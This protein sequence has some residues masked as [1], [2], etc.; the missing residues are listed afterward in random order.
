M[1]TTFLSLRGAQATKQSQFDDNRTLYNFKRQCIE[2]SLYGVDIDPGA[3]EIAKLRLWLSLVVD[4]EEIKNIKPLP[5]LDYRIMQGNSLISEFMGI[6]FDDENSK[7]S[8]NDL[9]IKINELNN[10]LSDIESENASYYKRN[11]KFDQNLLGRKNELNKIISGLQKKKNQLLKKANT[12]QNNISSLIKEFEKKKNEFLNESNVTR[13]SQLKEEVDDLLVKIFETKLKKQKTDYFSVLKNIENK[14]SGLRNEKQKAE[15]IKTE[16]EKLYKESGFDLESA[17]KQLK[18]FSSERKIKPFFLWNLYFSEVFHNKGGFDVVIANPPYG[19]LNKRQN[20]AQTIVVTPQEFHYYK[21]S[22]EY[23]SARGGM[24][25][26]FRLFILKSIYLIQNSGVLSEIFPLAFIADASA[27]KLRKYILN[28]C[29][30]QLIEAFPERDNIRKR[31]FEEVKMSVCVMVLTGDKGN[32][33]D[34]FFIRIHYDRYVNALNE[35]TILNS[36]LIKLFDNNKYTIPLMFQ[37]DIDL[38]SKIY[39]KSIRIQDMGHCYTGEVDMTLGKKYISYNKNNAVLL[40]GAGIDR[41]LIQK[42]MSQGELLYLKA[43]KYLANASKEKIKHSQTQRIV[44]QAI[45][46]VNEKIRLKMTLIDENI[47]CANS[48]N[49]IISNNSDINIKYLLGVLNSSLINYIFCKFSTNSNV[50]GYEVDNLPFPRPNKQEITNGIIQLVD[51]ILNI[52]RTEDYPQNPQKQAKVKA[53][54]AE[55]DQLVYNLYDLTPEEIKIV[56]GENENAD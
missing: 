24:I 34:D 10:D 49:Y 39:K 48:V 11:R 5:N 30:L 40:R 54:E 50:N 2:H 38:I 27:A 42:R 8:I 36:N 29:S 32:T 15:L 14:Y 37:N 25:N 28:R 16:K 12:D 13:K 55:I 20:K 47:F 17:E 3:V 19:L 53:I 26:I 1:L 44:L 43:E 45:T 18:E 22:T 21:T 46:G 31:V 6:N 52:T 56:E 41:Y 7:K 23:E 51:K 33:D 35:K 4:E 9:E